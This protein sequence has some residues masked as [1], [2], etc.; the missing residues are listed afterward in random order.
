MEKVSHR[1][2]VEASCV[3]SVPVSETSVLGVDQSLS[4]RRWMRRLDERGERTAMALAQRHTLPEIVA[5]VLAGRGVD[6]DNAGRELTPTI[7]ELMPDPSTL[8]ACDAL[9]ARLA[10]A[11]DRGERI[12]LFADYDV[13]GATSAAVVARTLAHLAVT[14]RIVIPDRITDGY[15]PSIPAME[16]LADEGTDVLL[17]LDCGAGAIEPVAAA[18]ARGMTVL[19]IDHHPVTALAP[20][21]HIVNPNRPDDLSGL[22]DCAAVGVAFIVMVGLMREMRRR[23]RFEGRT[24]PSLMPLL[25]CVALGTVAD[26]V[27]LSPL[28]RAFVTR[29]LVALRRRE[30]LGLAALTTVSKL[31]GPVDAG[32]LGFVLGPRINAGGRIGRSGLGARL[33]TSD[34]P[35]ET[36]AIATELDRLNRERRSLET[37]ALAEATA[38]VDEDAAVIVVAGRWHPGVV[39]LVAARLKERFRKPALAI[40]LGDEAGTGSGRSISGVDLGAA[41]REAAAAG[42]LLKGGGHAM[43]AGLTVAPERIEALTAWLTERLGPAVREAV[44]RDTLKIDAIAAPGALDEPLARL[45]TEHGPWGAGRPKPVIALDG[46]YIDHVMKVGTGESLKLRLSGRAGPP[47]EAML[48][49][50]AGP[51]GDRLRAARGATVNIAVEV[52]HGAFRGVPRADITVVDVAEISAAVRR[53]A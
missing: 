42:L 45:L 26:V 49:R 44:L 6:L 1:V 3:Q 15:G 23:G 8:T 5:R 48:F 52:A 24:E 40:G 50:P 17:C 47:I 30:N 7:R 36:E 33:L 18:K 22:S 41:I 28:N 19:V 29:G 32:H 34:D 37:A 14:P 2:M 10:D 25:D 4:G 43:A 31:S 13:D 38:L 39:G 11:I 9:V 20:A 51:V 16:A 12:V 21:D 27:P 46:A 35:A 53:A